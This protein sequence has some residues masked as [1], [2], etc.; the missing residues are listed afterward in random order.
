[1]L[2]ALGAPAL[3]IHFGAPDSRILPVSQP[4]RAVADTIRS[5]FASDD[6]D[7]IAVVA[8]TASATDV[9]DYADRLSTIDGVQRVDWANGTYVHGVPDPAAVPD[10]ERMVTRDGHGTRLVVFPTR[11]Q[12]DD[13]ANHL[14]DRIRAAPAPVPV[15]VGGSPAML[16][17]YTDGVV[18]RLPLVAVLIAV[19]TFT[20]LFLMSGSV[21]APLKATVLNLA[22]LTIMFSV[23]VWGFQDGHL[24]GLLGF[25]PS[26]S[27]EASIPILMF[28]VAYGLSMDYEVFLLSRIKEEYDRTG[29]TNESVVRGISRSAPLIGVAAGI[30]A[31]SF[32][33]YATSGVTFLKELGV[34]MALAVLVDATIIRGL[35]VPSFMRLAG[36]WNWW[37]PAPLRA[38]HNRIGLAEAG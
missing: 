7:V 12:L 37:A 36:P 21:I 23:L 20:V 32:A 3:G 9:A 34:G 17:D 10:R 30:L 25:T 15:L 6:S 29:D 14:V 8:P 24:A 2:L 5:D 28:C 35:L 16:E 18:G 11:A 19:V 31:L 22:S 27:I 1:V 38:L 26:G 13:G 33:I 4:V